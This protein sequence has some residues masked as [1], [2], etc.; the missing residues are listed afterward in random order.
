MSSMS[1][2]GGGENA[3][4]RTSALGVGREGIVMR[5]AYDDVEVD[6]ADEGRIVRKDAT[7]LL[8][9][10]SASGPNA[11]QSSGRAT[12]SGVSLGV[13]LAEEAVSG[14]KATY[15]RAFFISCTV[16]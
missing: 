14:R 9:A 6:D 4:V 8:R 10:G 7:E 15:P 2:P 3:P 5:L 12:S 16:W 1:V 13:S 11:M